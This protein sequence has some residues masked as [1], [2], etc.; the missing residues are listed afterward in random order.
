MYVG[1]GAVVS[2]DPGAIVMLFGGI[3][4][5]PI[6]FCPMCAKATTVMLFRLPSCRFMFVESSGTLI[7]SDHCRRRLPQGVF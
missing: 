6:G 1:G 7:G 2:A 3:H 4:T 5:W